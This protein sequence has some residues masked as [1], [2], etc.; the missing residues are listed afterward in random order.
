[1]C[2][3]VAALP[4]TMPPSLGMAGQCR[5]PRPAGSGDQRR[6]ELALMEAW[7][8]GL[9]PPAACTARGHLMVVEDDRPAGPAGFSAGA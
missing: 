6:A 4:S 9:V 2:G 1:V 5:L 3:V 7:P 8:H